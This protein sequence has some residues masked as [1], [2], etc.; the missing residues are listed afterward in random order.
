MRSPRASAVV[1][2][3]STFVAVAVAGAVVSQLTP[4][5]RAGAALPDGPIVVTAQPHP[6]TPTPTTT[7]E[8]PPSPESGGAASD[9]GTESDAGGTTVVAPAPAATVEPEA[10]Q[11]PAAAPTSPGNSG[12]APGQTSAPGNS[13][14]APGQNKP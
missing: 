2:A 9:P 14:D 7:G 3:L 6:A 1:V 12:S 5:D 13:G 10:T 4:L 11:P 8:V